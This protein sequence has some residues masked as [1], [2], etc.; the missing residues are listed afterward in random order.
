MAMSSKKHYTTNPPIPCERRVRRMGEDDLMSMFS[1]QI[2]GTTLR[3]WMQEED[4]I[5][6]WALVVYPKVTPDRWSAI[7]A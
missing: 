7:V 3:P 4:K 1:K 2:L 6:E 5:F